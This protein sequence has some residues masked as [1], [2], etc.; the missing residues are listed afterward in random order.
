[1][2][3]RLT[4]FTSYK[5]RCWRVRVC[6]CTLAH[7]QSQIWICE[8][9]LSSFSLVNSQTKSASVRRFGEPDKRWSCNKKADGLPHDYYLEWQLP[10]HLGNIDRLRWSLLWPLWS[11]TSIWFHA[12]LEWHK[13]NES[14]KENIGLNQLWS[15]D[16]KHEN[17]CTNLEIFCRWATVNY[18]TTI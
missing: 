7:V 16:K 6:V 18:V 3:K 15:T 2:S 4:I 12:R 9:R 11:F 14:D 10:L 17:V 8:K 1:M 13:Q 5:S